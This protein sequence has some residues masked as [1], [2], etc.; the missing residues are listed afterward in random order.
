[1]TVSMRVVLG[2]GGELREHAAP[3]VGV[4]NEDVRCPFV[5]CDGGAVEGPGVAAT[6]DEE[7]DTRRQSTDVQHFV[8]HGVVM[9]G[10]GAD[11][12]VELRGRDETG[13]VDEEPVIAHKG[14][15]LVDIVRHDCPRP[16]VEE[17][18]ELV[19]VLSHGPAPS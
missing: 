15:H 17:A 19:V 11:C 7:R 18:R 13:L 16:A 12:G 5:R 2:D 6:G 3:S 4:P 9:E 8:G 10:S 1:M 14:R